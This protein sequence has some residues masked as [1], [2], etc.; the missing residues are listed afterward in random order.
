MN[1][2]AKLGGASAIGA[3]SIAFLRPLCGTSDLR[4]SAACTSFALT[5]KQ[6]FLN[7]PLLCWA[8]EIENPVLLIHGA[9]AH[10]RYFSETTFEKMTGRKVVGESAK[11]GNKE[12]MI[13]PGAV[14]CDLYDNLDVI[15][16]DKIESFYR[17][18]LK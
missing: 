13:I 8:H 9:E 12:M 10:S 15:P 2:T 18:N 17:E 6:S 1:S 14:H 4:S 5:G 3:S 16:F 11:E 7:Q